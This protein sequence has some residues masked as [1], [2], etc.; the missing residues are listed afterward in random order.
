MDT[1]C[2]QVRE[3]LPELLGQQYGA[4]STGKYKRRHD[5]E[6]EQRAPANASL[7]LL[8]HGVAMLCQAPPILDA[9]DVLAEH[10]H[11]ALMSQHREHTR[12]EHGRHHTYQD[13]LPKHVPPPNGTKQTDDILL[14]YGCA[15]YSECR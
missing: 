6:E 10:L 7:R 3:E 2:S 1:R 5:Q 12:E 11:Q 8:I 4:P 14:T 15:H 9:T 13:P